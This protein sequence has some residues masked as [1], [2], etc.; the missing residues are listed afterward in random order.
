MT[1][2]KL[3]RFSHP[4]SPLSGARWCAERRRAGLRRA[5]RRACAMCVPVPLARARFLPANPLASL[6]AIT[7]LPPP[8]THTHTHTS[9]PPPPSAAVMRRGGRTC[10]ETDAA[11]NRPDPLLLVPGPGP[12]IFK[13]HRLPPPTPPPPHQ[14]P[15]GWILA[16]GRARG[17]LR[18]VASL[19]DQKKKKPK[20]CGS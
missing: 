13:D 12:W 1:S 19:C 7:P 15:P 16:G 4:V 14:P 2:E 17:A 10:E 5:A 11:R 6:P 9:L 3:Q 18:S 8:H 20:N